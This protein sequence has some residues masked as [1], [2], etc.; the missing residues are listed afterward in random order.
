[1]DHQHDQNV[2]SPPTHSP[3]SHRSPSHQN[4]SYHQQ[5]Q[6]HQQQIQRIGGLQRLTADL[7]GLQFNDAEALLKNLP[8]P[9]KTTTRSGWPPSTN[10]ANQMVTPAP[11]NVVVYEQM[12]PFVLPEQTVVKQ[13]LPDDDRVR[14]TSSSQGSEYDPVKDAQETAEDAVVLKRYKIISLVGTGNYARVYKA[15][16]LAQNSKEVAVKAINLN[17]TSDNYKQKF[18]PR[19]LNILRKINHVNICKIY[20]IIQISD[21]IF[22]VM[23]FCAKGTIADLLQKNGPLS[24]PLTRHL[25][26][27][28]VDAIV[29]LHS[30]DLAHRDIK[31]ENILLDHEYSPKLT[32][33][34]YSVYTGDRAN[35]KDNLRTTTKALGN[36]NN[37]KQTNLT[38]IQLNETFCGTLPYLSPEMIRQFPYDSKKTDVWSLGICFYVMLNDRLPFPFNDIK[39]MVKK[40]LTKDYKFKANIDVSEH[41]REFISLLLEPDFT[42]RPSILEASRHPWMNGPRERPSH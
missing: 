29:Y 40:Q 28:T 23:Q 32:D 14:S 13:V 2:A 35:N 12:Q 15:L 6:M 27:P 1:M 17:K 25:F 4:L 18:L 41:C 19:E 10:P 22:I 8:L 42:K 16:A 9:Q 11:K 21:R 7:A 26:V 39:L 20:E 37:N 24:E 31:V 30:L 34:S 33:F 3:S 5:Q 38:R 36:N